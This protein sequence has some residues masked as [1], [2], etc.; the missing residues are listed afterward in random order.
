MMLKSTIQKNKEVIV[1]LFFGGCTTVINIICFGM[2]YNCLSVS[3]VLS[4]VIAWCV[5]VSF[6]YYANKIFVFE[7]RVAG[8]SQQLKEAL[9]FFGCRGITL[10]FDVA[11]MEVTVSYFG[12]NEWLWKTISNVI[13]IVLN[14]IASKWWIFKKKDK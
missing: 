7:S 1:Y 10:L 12:W 4:N 11:I 13:V 2:L 6:A 8:L 9:S 3:N 14:Y 5:S